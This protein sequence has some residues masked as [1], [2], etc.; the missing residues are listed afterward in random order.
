MGLTA[1]L[2]LARAGVPVT[3]LERAPGLAE[4]LRA[5]TWHPPTLDMMAELGLI[6]EMLE[7]GLIARC[8]QFRDRKTGA[9]AQFD[10]ELLRGETQHPYRLQYEQHKYARLVYGRL[11]AFAHAKVLFDSRVAHVSQT[12]SHVEATLENGETHRGDYLIGADGARSAVRQSLGIEFEGFTFPERYYSVST[13]FDFGAHLDRLCYVNYVADTEEWCVLLKVSGM[14]RCLFPTRVDESDEE[15]LSDEATE[16]RL[17]G[18][19]RTHSRYETTHRTLYSVHQRVATRYRVGCAFLAG[20]A[21]HLNNPIGG[22]GMNGGLHDVLNLCD[23]LVQV[24]RGAG[25][26]IL[27]PYEAQRRPIAI[28]YINA[29]TARNRQLLQERD[30]E[31]RR[32]SQEEMCRMAEDPVAAKAFLMKGSMIDAVRAVPA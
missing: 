8:T 22:M 14:W 21:A 10:L 30:P 32:R 4:D 7:N 6:D 16:A 27:D 25:A 12:A 11:K 3:V 26:A 19:V 18:L 13:A 31:A 29:G 20:D 17:Q 2:V 9:I 15:V 24:Q 23:K 5:S 28:D 1:A